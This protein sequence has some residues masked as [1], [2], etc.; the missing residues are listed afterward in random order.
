MNVFDLL[1][2]FNI[3]EPNNLKG[4][5]PGFVVAQVEP[6][7]VYDAQNKL[8][9]PAAAEAANKLINATKVNG[10]YFVENGQ[11]AQLTADGYI[12]YATNH[13]ITAP[14]FVTYTEE[15]LTIGTNFEY[16]AAEI[17]EDPARLVQLIPGDEFTTTYAPNSAQMATAIAD[18]RIA[19]ITRNYIT[20]N[21]TATDHAQYCFDDFLDCNKFADGQPSYTY[22][23]LK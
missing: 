1:P 17:T 14:I 9:A 16:F 18:G 12:D 20:G 10:Y 15:R 3:I 8:L 4:L 5:Q 11:L 21:T 7:G 13:D 23:F 6:K 22:V 19:C 2:K